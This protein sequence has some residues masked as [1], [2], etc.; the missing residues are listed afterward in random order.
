MA[1]PALLSRH[2]SR[3]ASQAHGRAA[4]LLASPGASRLLAL[5]AVGELVADKLPSVPARIEIPS[6]VG[7]AGSGALCGAAVAGWRGEAAAGA[8]LA[9]AV[10][11]LASTFLAYHLRKAA[12]DA[13]GV[14]D[15]VLALA[16]DALA[17]VA[18]THLSASA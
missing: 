4:R 8:A 17:L 1:A 7:R 6:L 3:S 15:P 10:G 5:M 11:A 12:G 18:G 9:G 13:T 14:P 2:F 16:E